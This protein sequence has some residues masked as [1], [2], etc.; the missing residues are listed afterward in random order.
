MRIEKINDKDFD[1]IYSQ[2][3]ENFILDEI[4]DKPQA[5]EVLSDNSYSI[6]NIIENDIKVG[7]ISTW[8]FNDFLFVEHFVIYKKYR[9]NGYG[10]KAL[11][12]IKDKNKLVVLEV[13]MPTTEIAT[14]RINFYKSNGFICNDY[15]YMQPSYRKG[16]SEVPLILMS[17]L[18]IA[19]IENVV[20][21]IYKKV[22]KK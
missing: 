6:Y 18:K 15:D 12:L 9:K 7:F 8:S 13:E 1:F 10:S 14:N 16:G 11:S 5:Y 3:Q 4:R 20:K 21:S 22:Y 19:N 17:T 2:M